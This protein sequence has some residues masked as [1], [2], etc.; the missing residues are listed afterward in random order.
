MIINLSFGCQLAGAVL[1]MFDPTVE[2]DKEPVSDV[3]LVPLYRNAKVVGGVLPGE[4][5]DAVSQFLPV[6]LLSGNE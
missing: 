1:S 6:F 5:I 2:P 3:K 4:L